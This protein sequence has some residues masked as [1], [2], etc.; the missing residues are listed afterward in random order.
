MKT[1]FCEHSGTER[2]PLIKELRK[3]AQHK[4]VKNKMSPALSHSRNSPAISHSGRSRN[5]PALSHS[6]HSEASFAEAVL[7]GAAKICG[8]EDSDGVQRVCF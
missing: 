4:H 2:P 7:D 6:G 1:Y 5:S 8:I 3:E